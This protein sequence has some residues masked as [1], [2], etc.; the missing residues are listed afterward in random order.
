M[1]VFVCVVVGFFILLID[2]FM[3]VLLQVDCDLF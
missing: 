2:L 1:F 3:L